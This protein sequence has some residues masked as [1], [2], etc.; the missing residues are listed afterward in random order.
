MFPILGWG[1]FG[2]KH[3]LHIFLTHVTHVFLFKAFY[4]HFEP[5]CVNSLKYVFTYS[6]M[7]DS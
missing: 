1:S 7:S 3:L 4:F 2:L 5:S 6:Y